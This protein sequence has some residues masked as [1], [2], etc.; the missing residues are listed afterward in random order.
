M[1]KFYKHCKYCN[2]TLEEVGYAKKFYPHDSKK[3][4]LGERQQTNLICC[5]MSPNF[6]HYFGDNGM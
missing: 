6:E 1:I 4:D 5:L 3:Y 2:I